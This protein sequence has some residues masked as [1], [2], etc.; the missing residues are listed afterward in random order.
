MQ[1]RGSEFG[2]LE[3]KYEI[4]D[5]ADVTKPLLLL[6]S[7][8]FTV[9]FWD[10]ASSV[11]AVRQRLLY[12]LPSLL[13]DF[14]RYYG[15]VCSK[16]QLETRVRKYAQLRGVV[17]QVRNSAFQFSV[18]ELEFEVAAVEHQHPIEAPDDSL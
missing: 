13:F 4:V 2:I 17:K 12:H 6:L 14:R 7:L 16:L 11:L 9:H 8:E 3:C 18:P 10:E 1:Y 5:Y 15:Q